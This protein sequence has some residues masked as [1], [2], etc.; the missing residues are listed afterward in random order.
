MNRKKIEFDESYNPFS[1]NNFRKRIFIEDSES[2]DS[3]DIDISDITTK[4]SK[5][6]VINS[7]SK[8][9]KSKSSIYD[10]EMKKQLK[11]VLEISRINHSIEILKQP[12]IKYAHIYC[13]I[14]QLS[15]QMCGPLIEKFIKTKYRMIKNNASLCIGDLCHNQKN[16]E[17]KVSTGGKDNNKFNYV[18]I[19][20][21]HVCEYILTAY[22]LNEDNIDILGELYIFKLD[23]DD[24]KNLILKYGGYA[25]GTIKQLGEITNEKLQDKLNNN[26]YALRPNYGDKCWKELLKHRIN[27]SDI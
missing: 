20:M 5:M 25:H 10:I 14:N 8:D 6:K 11:K 16:F 3:D 2:S 1:V 26:E 27:E 19:R 7:D 4:F 22:H 9:N 15:G 23:K 21:S 17:I 18:Q 13:K 24:I 12:N